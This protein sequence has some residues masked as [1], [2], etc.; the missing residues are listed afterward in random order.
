[1]ASQVFGNLIAAF[2]LG[3]LSQTVY[4]SIMGIIAFLA[5]ISFLFVQPPQYVAHL[6][7]LDQKTADLD[8]PD[9]PARRTTLRKDVN[10]VI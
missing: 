4:F 2:A 9:V 1:M 5:T 10:G 8:E 6:R 7:S 3:Y